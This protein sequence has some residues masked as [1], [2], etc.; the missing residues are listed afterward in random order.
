MSKSFSHFSKLGSK[1]LLLCGY[2]KSIT[3]SIR[4]SK[5]DE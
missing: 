4:T 5:E 3:D 1:I 2:K